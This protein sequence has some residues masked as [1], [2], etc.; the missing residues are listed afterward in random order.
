MGTIIPIISHGMRVQNNASSTLGTGLV[1]RVHVI[2]GSYYSHLFPAPSPSR[3]VLFCFVFC[4]SCL[5]WECPLSGNFQNCIPRPY[6]TSF[7][8]CKLVVDRSH[9]WFQFFGPSTSQVVM[10]C[11]YHVSLSLVSSAWVQEFTVGGKMVM[12]LL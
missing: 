7:L 1:Y 12:V 5:S 9:I 3:F 6:L 2:S 8:S 10:G 11:P 4:G